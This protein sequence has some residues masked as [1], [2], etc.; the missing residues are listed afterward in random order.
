MPSSNDYLE[1]VLEQLGGL[2]RVRS[3]R[4]FG[5]FGLYCAEQFFALIFD[6]TLY[7]KVGDSNRADYESRGMA[8]FRP[9]RDRPELSM[10]YYTVPAEVLEDVEEA[11]AWA[12]R[13]VEAALISA[14][15]HRKPGVVKRRT[16]VKRK[17]TAKTKST[18]AKRIRTRRN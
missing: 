10:T 16:T 17:A 9:H 13:S 6:D 4:M 14:N 5:G 12:R 15:T 18:A 7:F 2:G 1:Y 8:R 11:V 3:R